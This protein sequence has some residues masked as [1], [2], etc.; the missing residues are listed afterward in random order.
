[1]KQSITKTVWKGRQTLEYF[2]PDKPEIY[3][4]LQANISKYTF[5]SGFIHDKVVLDVACGVG[6]GSHHLIKKGA[7][8]VVGGD[9]S[10]GAI[11]YARA[12]YKSND[13]QFVRLNAVKLPFSRDC[14]DAIVSFETIEHL[15][16]YENFL[17]ECK[18]V[19]KDKGLFICSTPNKEI[20]SPKTEK[21]S[22]VYHFKEFHISEFYDLLDK[23]FHNIALYGQTY[24]SNKQKIVNH[25]MWHVGDRLSSFPMGEQ[26][27][28]FITK[29]IFRENRRVTL[30]IEAALD[31]VSDKRYEPTPLQDNPLTP[32]WI[33]A[34]ATVDKAR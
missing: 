11:E 25:I 6:Y 1:M 32:T 14:F 22:W 27:K 2:V 16:E 26:L 4:G 5:A 15:K 9:I 24:V 8:K 21:P 30:G 34:L 19:L 3:S 12:Q 33:I 18:R 7:K 20:F 13:L 10:E 23:H 31:E 28:S 17:F 29:F